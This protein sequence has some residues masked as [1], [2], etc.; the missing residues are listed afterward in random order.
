MRNSSLSSKEAN[1]LLLCS[2]MLDVF[3]WAESQWLGLLPVCLLNLHILI[4]GLGEGLFSLEGEGYNFHFFPLVFLP[5]GKVPPWSLSM[6]NLLSASGK[7][8]SSGQSC[9]THASE[10]AGIHR[11]VGSS[12]HCPWWEVLPLFTAC[13]LL[14]AKRRSPTCPY[15][16]RYLCA[17]VLC[18]CRK[19]HVTAP[20]TWCSRA[21]RTLH[22]LLPLQGRLY[23]L[24]WAF[25]TWEAGSSSQDC[26]FCAPFSAIPAGF[27]AIR[28]VT[29]A[30]PASPGAD[31]KPHEWPQ[32]HFVSFLC[33]E[34]WG[35]PQPQTPNHRLTQSWGTE[36][37]N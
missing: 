5:L 23:S 3:P 17:S 21:L 20:V 13:A 15:R 33:L 25:S 9:R 30:V 14:Q 10:Q 29:R 6:D 7:A 8:Y 22:N 19:C 12:P 4:R 36:L 28:A 34:E 35:K 18:D 32:E 1:N 16:N 37:K 27:S 24:W 31:D 11:V 26:S 2:W